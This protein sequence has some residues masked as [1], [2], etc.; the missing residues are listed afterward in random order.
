MKI[1]DQNHDDDRNQNQDDHNH[2]DDD[3]LTFYNYDIHNRSHLN[4][5][6][7]NHNHSSNNGYDDNNNLKICNHEHHK[8][9]IQIWWEKRPRC[10]FLRTLNWSKTFYDTR[11]FAFEKERLDTFVD[12]PQSSWISPE[13]LAA[14]GFY[15]LRNKDLCACYFCQ[16]IVGD[17][18]KDDTPLGEH[19]K[20]FPH[21]PFVR[22]QPTA[23]INLGQSCIL[24]QII[25]IPE[26][27]KKE[28]T[29]YSRRYNTF[30][31]RLQSFNTNL[32]LKYWP[33][34]IQQQRLTICDLAEAGFYYL[35]FFDMVRCFSC[36]VGLHNWEENEEPW[37]VHARWSSSCEFLLMNKE[38]D[39][40]KKVGSRSNSS[41]QTK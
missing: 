4:F 34:E 5:C 29:P 13:D 28:T 33:L 24:D 8:C 1:R 25:P 23:N 7:Y 18:E 14:A 32:R 20:H 10:I 31:V 19:N 15:Y 39:F 22:N 27:K 36:G 17:W 11:I 40:I 16:G 3:N 30:E 21:C 2:S 26:T 12:W 35:G 38:A 41:L 6:N 37:N 9:E